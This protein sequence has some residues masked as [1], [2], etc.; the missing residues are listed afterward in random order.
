[1]FP[2]HDLR[3]NCWLLNKFSPPSVTMDMR[4][5]RRQIK[6]DGRV[7]CATYREKGGHRHGSMRLCRPGFFDN[8]RTSLTGHDAKKRGT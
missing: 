4:V 6:A 8:K 5:F 2:V 7:N 3:M 1:M